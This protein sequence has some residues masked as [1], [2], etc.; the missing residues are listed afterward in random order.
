MLFSVSR[1]VINLLEPKRKSN[2]KDGYPQNRTKPM[3]LTKE[4]KL[5]I[6]SFPL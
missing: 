1:E 6:E 3:L 5:N 2:F 4:L